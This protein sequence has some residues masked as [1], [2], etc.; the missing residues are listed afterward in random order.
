ME[1][2]IST[3][4][5]AIAAAISIIIA[6]AIDKV[7]VNYISMIIG[8]IIGL[9]PFLNQQIASFDSEIFM[10]LIVAPLLFFE[11]QKT[12]I[13]NVGRR[14]KEIIGLTIIMVL[15]ALIVSGFSIHLLA[16]VSLPLAFIIGSISTPTDAT[17][18]EAVTNGLR[19]PRRV[20]SALKAESLFNDASGIILL[21]MSLLW[22]ANGYINYGQTIQDFC[23][24][25][26]GGAILGFA[27]AWVIIIFRQTLVRSRFNSLNAQNLI[28]ILTPLALYALA[29]HLH[30]SGIIA[31]V[32]AGLLHNAESQQS[33]LLNSRQVHMSQDLQNLISDIF[34]SM[35]FIILGLMMVRISRNKLFN[36]DL[37]KWIIV[38]IIVYLAN[39]LVR[40][41]YGRL[42]IR[43]DRRES[44]VFSLGGIHGAVTLAL[45]LALTI[46][47]DFLGSQ[48]YNLVIMSE[49]VLI[50]LSMLVPTIVFQFILPHNVSDEEAH[51][52]M[53]KIRSEMVKR[54][55][56]AVHKMYLP[57]RVK[58]HVIYTLLNQKRVVKTREYIRVLL[59]TI[60]QPNLSK[61]EQY[62][63][64]LAFFRAFA[65]ER[66]Y[67]EMIGQKEGKYRTYIL[68][69]YND[70][71]L[72]ESLI[73]EPEDE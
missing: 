52:V 30:V 29:E 62:L 64:R 51:I 67:L 72:A 2:M 12:R 47:V 7:S 10:E 49:A 63:Q 6:Q 59:K 70:V 22:F 23:I 21:N 17:A 15:L 35:V 39:L 41:L 19:M 28:Y 66:E 34:N 54:A 40:Y 4:T 31:V 50:I 9:I 16:D 68:N 43:Y 71:L 25:S 5:L 55:L 24:S 44:I 42:I 53:D 32:V 27:V 26:I 73:I 18:S 61:S 60:D 8:I 56:V 69:L 45:A 37:A 65:I 1:L 11:G 57:Q 48:S 3:F 38:G 58:R 33:L 13:H 20:T 36:G 14:I 46:S